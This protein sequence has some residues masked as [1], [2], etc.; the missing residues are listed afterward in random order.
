VQMIEINGEFL[1]Y[2][3]K[4]LKVCLCSCAL[5]GAPLGREC[6]P[7]TAEW[8]GDVKRTWKFT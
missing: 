6:T 3:G 8:C 4:P 5:E 2:D 7:V 1:L